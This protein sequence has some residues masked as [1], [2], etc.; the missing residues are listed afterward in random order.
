MKDLYISYEMTTRPRVFLSE[1]ITDLPDEIPDAQ[2]EDFVNA[3]ERT[4]RVLLDSPNLRWTDWTDRPAAGTDL[5]EIEYQT[6]V[7]VLRR[8]GK[9]A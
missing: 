2:I 3:R 1:H 9:R 6:T 4:L 7:A 8:Q 5:K